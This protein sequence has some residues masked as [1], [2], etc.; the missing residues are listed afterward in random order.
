MKMKFPV[1]ATVLSALVMT[2]CASNPSALDLAE[3]QAEFEAKRADLLAEKLERQ[4]E[5]L[6]DSLDNLPGWA[7]EPPKPDITGIY[8]VG[9]AESSNVAVV[10]K[11][12]R[13]QAEYEL[14]QQMQQEIS[15]L[16]QQF[17]EDSAGNEANLRFESAVERFVNSVEIAGQEIVEQEINVADGKYNGYVLMRLSF[18]S[19]ERMLEQ[20]NKMEG[21]DRMKVAFKQL[22]ERIEASEKTTNIMGKA[23][24]GGA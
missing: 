6:E 1:I 24:A 13:L 8:G 3:R 22:R 20:R 17:T 16:E 12:A 11:K 18:D 23:E 9:I 7:I 14:A 5:K 2:G 4:N 15:G 10:M 21:Y 19:M